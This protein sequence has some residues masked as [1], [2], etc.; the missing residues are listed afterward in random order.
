MNNV[1]IYTLDC[2]FYE[3]SSHTLRYNNVHI[4]NELEKLEKN[5]YNCN[6]KSINKDSPRIFVSFRVINNNKKLILNRRNI[7]KFIYYINRLECTSLSTNISFLRYTSSKYP[8]VLKNI[9]YLT[10][11]HYDK[12]TSFDLIVNIPPKLKYI[13]INNRYT[14]NRSDYFNYLKSITE[15]HYFADNDISVHLGY[16]AIYNAENIVR[17]SSFRN[18]VT[19]LFEFCVLT[20]LILSNNFLYMRTFNDNLHYVAEGISRNKTLTHIVIDCRDIGVS[21]VWIAIVSLSKSLSLEHILI[22]IN[23]SDRDSLVHYILIK[24]SLEHIT[25]N[26]TDDNRTFVNL[27]ECIFKKNINKGNLKTVLIQLM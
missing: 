7:D 23:A 3:V 14:E 26:V 27:H 2:T 1:G 18:S 22:Q 25:D 16:S 13:K 5:M 8:I 12:T 4:T 15:C 24:Y 20:K 6:A 10:I 19:D 11:C 21:Y 9:A 17:H